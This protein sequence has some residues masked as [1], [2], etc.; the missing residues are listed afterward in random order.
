MP[1]RLKLG[2]R[3]RPNSILNKK[4]EM[5]FCEARSSSSGAG[6][7]FN[8]SPNKDTVQYGNGS[9]LSIWRCHCLVLWCGDH[10]Q[11]PGGLRNTTEAKMFRRKLLSRPLGLRCDTE[12]VQPHLLGKIVAKFM[13][14]TAGSMADR[15]AS[16]LLGYAQIET[17]GSQV[18]DY[19]ARIPAGQSACF[20]A[21]LIVE[22]PKRDYSTPFN[23]RCGSL[24][25]LLCL[26]SPVFNPGPW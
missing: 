11:T 10:K 13:V 23:R 1:C 12:Y 19:M 18:V 26:N 16:F 25:R 21:A 4:N 17:L 15:W 6:V 8:R 9:Q 14:G 24:G 20:S 22:H 5:M 7:D 2:R 3:T